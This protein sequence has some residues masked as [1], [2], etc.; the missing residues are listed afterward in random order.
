M[1]KILF[2]ATGGTIACVE[3]ENGLSPQLSSD[4]LLRAVPEL[5]ELCDVDA[6]QLFS[7]DSTN[8]TPTEWRTVAERIS[9]DYADYDGFV[10][11]HGTDTLGYAAAALSCMI[12]GSGKPIILTGSQQPMGAEESD[13][14]P[15]L[16]DAFR[17]A[18]DGRLGGVAVVFG[19]RIIDGRCAVKAHTW[20]FDAF[21]SI[22]RDELGFVD[23]MNGIVLYEESAAEFTSHDSAPLFLCRMDTAVGLVKFIPAM[24]A[25]IL[26]YVAERCRVLIIEGFGKGGFPDYG[27]GQLEQKLA[28][29]ALGGVIVIMTTQVLDGGSDISAYEVGKAAAER[30]GV[31]DAGQM[32]TEYATMRAMWSLAYA[33]STEDFRELFL[34]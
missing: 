17:V 27:K 24:D 22:N 23:Q 4:A 26:D 13:A 30:L 8:M 19:G 33:S 28:E 10:I 21:R 6:V 29:L 32:T 25:G 34:R 3:T 15:N 9:A 11:S 31:I 16:R 7:L 2:I 14:R 20:K 12:Q 5:S 1:K 18:A